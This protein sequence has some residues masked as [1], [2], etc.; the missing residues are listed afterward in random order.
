ML[1]ELPNL[2]TALAAVT[3]AYRLPADAPSVLFALGRTVGW[4]AQSVEEYASD[5]LIRPRARY[6]GPMPITS[7]P[8]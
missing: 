3:H 8:T 1:A 5:R 2:D 7:G 6:T 4:I